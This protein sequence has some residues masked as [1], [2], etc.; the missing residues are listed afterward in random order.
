[1]LFWNTVLVDG[2][3]P[4]E[5]ILSLVAHSYELMARGLKKS[6]QEKIKGS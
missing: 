6:A 3:I 2:G 1:M 5:K 4:D